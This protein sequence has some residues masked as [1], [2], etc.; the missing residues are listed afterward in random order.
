MGAYIIEAN[1]SSSPYT[2]F[3][4]FKGLWRVPAPF[5]DDS[6]CTALFLYADRPERDQNVVQLA[7]LRSLFAVVAC[8]LVPERGTHRSAEF[9]LSRF[10]GRWRYDSWGHVVRGGEVPAMALMQSL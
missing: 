4:E 6:I 5:V 2:H 9:P 7:C 1:A 3:I 10:I 8:G